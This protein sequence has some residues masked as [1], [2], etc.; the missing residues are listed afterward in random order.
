M[1]RSSEGI[2]AARDY[3][4]LPETVK[5][6]MTRKQYLW[7]SDREKDELVAQQC[8]PDADMAD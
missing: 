8:E 7:L 3:D 1:P 6:G 2:R 4:A 5:H